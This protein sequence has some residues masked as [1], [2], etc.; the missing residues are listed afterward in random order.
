VQSVTITKPLYKRDW[1]QVLLTGI[2]LTIVGLFFI[3]NS[4][5]SSSY[6]GNDIWYG[7]FFGMGLADLICSGI[8]LQYEK[9]LR[10]KN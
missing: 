5:L 10:D 9:K 7:I 2:V 4:I 1:F 6:N 8:I 3:A